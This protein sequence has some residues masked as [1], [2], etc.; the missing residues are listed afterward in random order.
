MIVYTSTDSIAVFM[1]KTL[2]QMGM[3]AKG[4]R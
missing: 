1:G 2:I 3:L 4:I